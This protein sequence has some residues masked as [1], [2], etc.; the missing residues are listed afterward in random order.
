MKN[1][2]IFLSLIILLVSCSKNSKIKTGIENYLEE[3][4]AYPNNYEQLKFEI[5][6]TIT[7]GKLNEFEKDKKRYGETYHYNESVVVSLDQYEQ[8]SILYAT[9]NKEIEEYYNSVEGKKV[10][11]YVINQK[12]RFKKNSGEFEITN[13]EFAIDNDSNFIGKMEGDLKIYKKTK[14]KTKYNP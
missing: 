10:L 2:V 12:F 9:Q 3:N 13:L 8:D 11:G 14:K 4:V 7:N 6:D 5:I 1:I